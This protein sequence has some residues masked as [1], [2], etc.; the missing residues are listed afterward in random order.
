M[1]CVVLI[2]VKDAEEAEKIA[3][4][5]LEDKLIACANIIQGVKSLFWWE[6][7]L[8]SANELMVVVKTRRV[9]FDKVVKKVRKLHSYN[10]PEIIA[11]PVIKGYNPYLKWI[12]D[13][14]KRAKK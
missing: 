14:T 7:A 2:T 6:G 9:L 11:L 5:L 4:G 10:V 1:Y 8:D 3:R 13:S 12:N